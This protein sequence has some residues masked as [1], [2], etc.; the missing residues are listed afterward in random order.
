[1]ESGHAQF[2]WPGGSLA[3]R[4]AYTTEVGP[5]PHG[6]EIDHVCHTRDLSCKAGK[7]CLHRR[8]VNPAHLEPVTHAENNRR[9]HDLSEVAAATI[10]A[11]QR[12][13]THCPQSHEYTP[14]NTYVDKRGSR[15]CRA[16]RREK[17][18]ALD[19]KGYMR[20]YHLKRKQQQN[21]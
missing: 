14:E 12:T 5:I 16:C 2:V 6:L 18:G 13:K 4:Y 17:V 11:R 15:N 9:R 1:M 7:H 10:G 21:Q 3:H 19:R 8:C 20:E